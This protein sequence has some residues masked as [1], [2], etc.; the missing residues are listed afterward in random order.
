MLGSCRNE[1]R[2]AEATMRALGKQESTGSHLHKEEGH[3]KGR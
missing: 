2:L 3:K 1:V